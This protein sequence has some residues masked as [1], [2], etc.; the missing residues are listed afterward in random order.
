[1]TYDAEETLYG[2]NQAGQSRDTFASFLQQFIT[3]NTINPGDSLVEIFEE[4]ITERDV[5]DYTDE[6]LAEMYDNFDSSTDNVASSGLTLTLAEDNG[7][8]LNHYSSEL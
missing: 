3:D 2:L 7:L 1:M 4:Y 6:E 5:Y 8:H